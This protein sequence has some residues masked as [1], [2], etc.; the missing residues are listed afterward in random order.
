MG[1][2]DKSLRIVIA[3]DYKMLHRASDDIIVTTQDLSSATFQEQ[4]AVSTVDK[5]Q[6]S[7]D[8][9]SARICSTISMIFNNKSMILW[10]YMEAICVPMYF[11]L[12][13]CEE[14]QKKTEQTCNSTLQQFHPV[15]WMRQG[16]CEKMWDT[17]YFKTA[18][19]CI[20]TRGQ[21]K[22]AKES[23][24]L[25]LLNLVFYLQA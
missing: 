11:S 22:V 2:N 23:F 10:S 13:L 18:T 3:S 4:N 7:I 8:F 16:A 17:K 12:K 5:S 1:A 21:N 24:I 14:K 25:S 15:N 20:H 9:K 6:T 19:W